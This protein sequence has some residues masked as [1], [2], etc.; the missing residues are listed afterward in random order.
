MGDGVRGLRLQG[1]DGNVIV[2]LEQTWTSKV[3]AHASLDRN[4]AAIE[5]T[6]TR[7]TAVFE[8]RLMPKERR[9]YMKAFGSLEHE[10]GTL[11]PGDLVVVVDRQRDVVV[12]MFI[13]D[14][15]IGKMGRKL[16]P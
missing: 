13:A 6:I 14:F 10:D 16:W 8:S 15:A 11:G 2:P 9:I 5:E 3:H 12:T 4:W 7:A 1:A